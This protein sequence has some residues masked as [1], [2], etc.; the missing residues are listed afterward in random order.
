MTVL[1][2]T[3]IVGLA[4]LL[5]TLAGCIEGANQSA[6]APTPI[7]QVP[8][9][10]ARIPFWMSCPDTIGADLQDVVTRTL[11]ADLQDAITRMPAPLRSVRPRT[12]GAE[13]RNLYRDVRLVG[14]AYTM[15]EAAERGRPPEEGLAAE[16]LTLRALIVG[17][18][19]LTLERQRRPRR[20]ETLRGFWATDPKTDTDFVVLR[21]ALRPRAWA[22]AV[23]AMQVPYPNADNGAQVH[24]PFL[25]L[26]N[27]LAL[28]RGPF[29]G[30]LAAAIQ[31]GAFNQRRVTV[32]GHGVGG[33]LAILI[34]TALARA[35]QEISTHLI[36][37]AAPRPGN[38][39]FRGLTRAIDT[40]VRICNM[41]DLVP[42][43]P[44]STPDMTYVHVGTLRRYS[45]FDYDD[46]LN[47]AV[48]RTG[49]QIDCWHSLDAY[50]WMLDHGHDRRGIGACW[51]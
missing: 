6:G 31:N 39:A 33:A 35:P 47:N 21:G 27:A 51:K 25:E 7:L 28:D 18:P 2:K 37:V 17:K 20:N 15:L 49:T 40:A 36:T 29:E 26:Y 24:G 41:P 42:M 32:T 22:R 46:D 48:N 14:V 10:K 13:D 16:A 43:L 12:E 5:I 23:E 9:G 8:L 38:G 44:P 34:A 45:S 3:R 50:A 4:C 19:D 11:G 30:P 1:G